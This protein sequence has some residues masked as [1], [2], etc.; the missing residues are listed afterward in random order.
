MDRN[1]APK[2]VPIIP[3]IRTSGLRRGKVTLQNS[4]RKVSIRNIPQPRLSR[5]SLFTHKSRNSFGDIQSHQ[6]IGS[7]YR[8][9][10]MLEKENED[11]EMVD[12]YRFIKEKLK[13]SINATEINHETLRENQIKKYK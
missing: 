3:K 8:N 12:I 7:R 6:R 1:S 2:P 10:V 9:F 4:K 13:T 5:K 11:N